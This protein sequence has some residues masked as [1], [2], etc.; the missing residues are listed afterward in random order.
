MRPQ[1]VIVHVS[2]D[3]EG[4]E[5]AAESAGAAAILDKVD[6]GPAALDELWLE[7]GSRD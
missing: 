7:H 3:P 4:L 6:L 5:A 2:A 1:T